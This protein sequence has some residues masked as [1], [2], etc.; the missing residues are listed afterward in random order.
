MTLRG[1][2]SAAIAKTTTRAIISA[3]SWPP[4]LTLYDKNGLAAKTVPTW[5]RTFRQDGKIGGEKGLTTKGQR[6]D[7]T[8]LTTDGAEAAVTD[9]FGELGK[10]RQLRAWAKRDVEASG[11]SWSLSGNRSSPAKAAKARK[12]SLAPLNEWGFTTLKAW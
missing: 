4:M 9:Y 3:K 12:P 5:T 6:F 10:N 8:L 7:R 2:S 1:L 11:Y